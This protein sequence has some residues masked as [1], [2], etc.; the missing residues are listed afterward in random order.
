MSIYIYTI[1]P[2]SRCFV[3]VVGAVGG[4]TEEH[5]AEGTLAV[6]IPEEDTPGV[7]TPVVEG[8]LEED[9]LVE[10]KRPLGIL[11]EDNLEEEE[12]QQGAGSDC[13]NSFFFILGRKFFLLELG[14]REEKR[15]KW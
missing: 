5:T 12:H 4:R 6:G 13:N 14:R 7:G 9:T 15:D 2:S 11:Q 3:F 10:D 1:L 8:T